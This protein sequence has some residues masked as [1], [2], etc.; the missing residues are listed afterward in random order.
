VTK[1]RN[2]IHG[3]QN[4]RFDDLANMVDFC[5]T[6]PLGRAVKNENEKLYFD[7]SENYHSL[8]NKYCSK[9][10]KYR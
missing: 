9:R 3:F 6:G 7:F 5:H 4:V 10:Y 1:L 8:G 2:A